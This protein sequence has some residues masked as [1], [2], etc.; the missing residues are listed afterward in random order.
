M[1]NVGYA[2]VSTI[3]QEAGHESQIAALKAAGCDEIFEERVSSVDMAARARLADALRYVRRGDVFVV[4]KI[5]R[6]ARNIGHL[7]T[8]IDELKGKQVALRVLDL[9]M[10]TGTPTGELMLTMLGAIAQFERSIM[11]ER[12]REGIAK[13]KREGKLRGRAPTALARSA[14]VLELI[15][16]GKGATEIARKLGMSRRSV[17]A[18]LEHKRAGGTVPDVKAWPKLRARIEDGSKATDAT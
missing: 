12:Q 13:A 1:P 8:I 3:D 4:T 7:M 17:Y 18:V 9:N 16:K 2:R 6:L 5:D 15:D 14:E 10:E 11:L